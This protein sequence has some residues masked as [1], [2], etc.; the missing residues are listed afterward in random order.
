MKLLII[1]G[2]NLNLIGNREKDVYGDESLG[3][4]INWIQKKT[5]NIEI[6]LIWFQSK[7]FYQ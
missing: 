2:P 7:T 3:Q 1:N 6:D 4:I 5:K